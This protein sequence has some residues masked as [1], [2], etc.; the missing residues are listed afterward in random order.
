MFFSWDLWSGVLDT[1]EKNSVK[2]VLEEYFWGKS[3]GPVSLSCH[4]QALEF[5]CFYPAI[6]LSSGSG[7]FRVY[8]CLYSSEWK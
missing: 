7:K 8:I 2:R 5:Y 6:Y 4:V 3:S 1:R